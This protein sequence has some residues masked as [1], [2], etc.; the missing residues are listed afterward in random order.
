MVSKLF[1]LSWVAVYFCRIVLITNGIIYAISGISYFSQSYDGFELRENGNSTLYSFPVL[2]PVIKDT[3]I[4]DQFDGLLI[5][6]PFS[7]SGGKMAIKLPYTW[8]YWWKTYT[9]HLMPLYLCL[10]CSYHSGSCIYLCC[11]YITCC[12]VPVPQSGSSHHLT[13]TGSSALNAWLH[14]AP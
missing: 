1:A 12:C 14:C 9:H 10:S 3:V 7:K 8:S 4:K 11:I 13:S 6:A 5:L 2:E